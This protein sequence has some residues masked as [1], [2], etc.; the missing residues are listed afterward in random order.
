MMH[1]YQGKNITQNI[2]ILVAEIQKNQS[3]STPS[4]LAFTPLKL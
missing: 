2:P 3:L 4:N 1:P